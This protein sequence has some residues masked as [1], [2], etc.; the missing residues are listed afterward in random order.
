MKI[1][2]TKMKQA[3]EEA[4]KILQEGEDKAEAIVEAMEKINDAQ[5]SELI[6]EIVEQS[7]KAE[8]DKE[9]AK[10][11]GLRTLNKEEKEFF[12]ALKND[13]RQA[14]TGK[15]ADMLPS[16]FI[17]VTLEDIKKE[18]KLLNYINFAPANVKKWLTASKT[19]AYSW[20]GLTDKIK[21]EL[22]A[23]FAV[24]D[25][26]VCKLTVYLILPKAIRDLALPF[27]EK[28]CREILKEQLND[29][30]EYGALQGTGK[31]EPIGM[32]KQIAKTNEDGTHQDKEVNEK[33]TSFKPKALAPAK[34]Y[35]TKNGNRTID[36]LVLVC[37][38]NDEADYVAPAIYND[39][40]R[41][42]A[43][44]KN[45]EVV[46]CSNNP[47]GKALLLIPKKYTMG[48]TGLGFKDYDQT[49]ALDDADVI[50]GK[51]YAN[52]RA[53]DD[54]VA[55]VFDVT[56]LEEYIPTVKTVSEIAGA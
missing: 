43:S 27:V 41:M 18:S 24:L 13:P 32:Y 30:L 6:Q 17:D 48:L 11:L 20:G 8:S 21:G 1:N 7:N 37:H 49:M 25:M 54:N 16:T 52:G 44:Y 26:G 40:G 5:Y 31:N 15:Q 3:Q 23:S 35:L 14:V 12:E 28:Y 38:P 46:P 50:I 2:E 36:K 9:Y 42:I 10:T 4:L 22:T 47:E 53:S 29:G 45:L 39:E 56:K 33:L 51:G 34:K 19:G 55:F